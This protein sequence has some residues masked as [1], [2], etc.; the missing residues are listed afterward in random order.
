MKPVR[1]VCAKA[2][3]TLLALGVL[4]SSAVAGSGPCATTPDCGHHRCRR[5]G[6]RAVTC[7]VRISEEGSVA[8][9]TAQDS[10][11]NG[12]VCVTPG[13]KIKWFTSDPSSKFTVSF[14]QNPFGNSPAASFSGTDGDAPQGGKVSHLPADACYQYSVTHSASGSSASLDPKVIVK[15]AGLLTGDAA[16]PKPTDNK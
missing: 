5:S 7:Y 9:V 15:G 16:Q 4:V 8:T 11:G 14:V 1:L 12:D 13:T 3:S 6:H 10:I 2:G